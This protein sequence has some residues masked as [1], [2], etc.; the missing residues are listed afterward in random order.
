MKLAIVLVLLGSTLCWAQ[1]SSPPAPADPSRQTLL[2]HIQAGGA[3]G[4]F[5]L[6]LSVVGVALVVDAFMRLHEQKLIPPP[7]VEQAQQLAQRGRFAELLAICRTHDSF[8]ARVLAAGLSQGNW[9]IEAVRESMGQ[10]GEAE[11]TRLRQRVGYI[12]FLAAVAPMLGLL[13]TVVGLIQSFEVL[14]QSRGAARPDE[15]AVG[16]SV[17]MVTTELG[18][19]VAVPL[20]F[21][22]MLLRDRVTR[23]SQRCAA[24]CE[25]V[26]RVM[27]VV[28]ETRRT[29]ASATRPAGPEVR[30]E[31]HPQLAPG[32]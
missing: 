1:N 15:L 8:L 30:P 28:I 7:M 10:Q 18:L 14:G 11:V 16:I 26:I 22:H 23:I 21:F 13:G 25:R 31:P 27:S 32:S 5:I 24:E 20:M 9:G 6:V 29:Q 4:Y 12:A 3:I 17:A 2:E 19:I